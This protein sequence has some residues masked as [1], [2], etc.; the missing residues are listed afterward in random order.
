MDRRSRARG[1]HGCLAGPCAD[2]GSGRR[3][4]VF[5]IMYFLLIRPQQQ[6]QQELTKL[7]GA[8][9]KGDRVVTTSGI[10]GTIVGVDEDKAVLRVDENVKI[11]FQRSTIVGLV[12]EKK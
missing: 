3:R 6:R 5:V 11:E 1:G 7:Q 9:K 8:L 4:L 10:F 2:G 12:A